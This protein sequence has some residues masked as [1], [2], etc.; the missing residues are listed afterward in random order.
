MSQLVGTLE[1]AKQACD[2]FCLQGWLSAGDGNA[3]D[4]V[5]DV[6][7]LFDQRVEL[8]HLAQWGAVGWAHVDANTAFGTLILVDNYLLAAVEPENHLGTRFYTD[9]AAVALVDGVRVVTGDAIEVA[10]LQEHY[11]SVA[12]SIDRAKPDYIIEVPLGCFHD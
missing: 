3:G 5:G 4:E 9:P 8:D 6:F 1:R 11:E 10:P 2:E 12:R 7:Y